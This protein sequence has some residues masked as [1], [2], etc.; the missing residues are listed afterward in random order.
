VGGTIRFQSTVAIGSLIASST[1][2]QDF[3]VHGWLVSSPTR[4]RVGRS[5]PPSRWLRPTR[6]RSLLF[7]VAPGLRAQLIIFSTYSVVF[8]VFVY[9]VDLVILVEV[10]SRGCLDACSFLNE[11]DYKV[12]LPTELQEL[13]QD[14]PLYF[15]SS[16]LIDFLEEFESKDGD[17]LPLS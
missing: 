6:L 13:S 4:F 15:T 9:L 5:S 14:V 17:F 12:E 8:N 10:V 1:G 7:A 2:T 3:V 16:H 11:H